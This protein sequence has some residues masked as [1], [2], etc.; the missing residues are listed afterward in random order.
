MP[1][2]DRV[3][4]LGGGGMLA[5][6]LKLTLAPRA[7]TVVAPTR[8]HLDITDPAS[9]AKTF[10]NLRPTLVLNCAAH[11]KVDLCDYQRDL[12]HAINARAAGNAAHLAHAANAPFVQY[13]TDFVFSGSSPRPWVETD[14][15]GPLSEYGR[16][17]L[18]GEQLVAANH[19]H[20]LILRTSWLYGP[21]GPCFPATMVR[22][23]KLRK[24]LAIVADQH[25]SPTYT[26]DLAEYTL[27][28][29]DAR[30][31]GTFHLSNSGET[32][33][34]D[35]TAEILRTFNLTTELTKITTADWNAKTPWSAHRPSRSTMN[36]SK[37][38]ATLGRPP[39]PWQD[40]LTAYHA[41]SPT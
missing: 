32:T 9:L 20:A 25:G 8:A 4:I 30:A 24:P 21:G 34:H 5:H 14:P 12:A 16:S 11:T 3:L 10:A 37:A 41:A 15:V 28:L 38:A 40:A 33:W 29:L 1:L 27:A 26:L 7:G 6:A 2:Y 36:C 18:A 13:S 39:R 35:F 22:L 23:A 19:P 31:S 17:K